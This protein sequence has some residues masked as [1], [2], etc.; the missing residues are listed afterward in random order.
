MH[1]AIDSGN[2]IRIG[3]TD[4]LNTAAAPSST[5]FFH[6]TSA[7]FPVTNV[8][9]TYSRVT[10]SPGCTVDVVYD[11]KIPPR[12]G[13]HTGSMQITPHADCGVGACINFEYIDPAFNAAGRCRI[14]FDAQCQ[15]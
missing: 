7:P 3:N 5:Y 8:L 1:V 13:Y 15:A 2:T 10:S 6:P 12:F 11:T 9:T 14:K 4:V